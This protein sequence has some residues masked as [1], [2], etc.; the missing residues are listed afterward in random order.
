MAYLGFTDQHGKILGGICSGTYEYPEDV[1]AVYKYV[2]IS[3]VYGN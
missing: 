2:S 3:F 1:I